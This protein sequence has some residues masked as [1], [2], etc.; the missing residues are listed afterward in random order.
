M[1][2][3]KGSQTLGKYG[4]MRKTYLQEH[5]KL[6]YNQMLLEGS[7]WPHLCKIDEDA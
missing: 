5:H 7:L 1:A 3:T 4:R 6:L 2:I